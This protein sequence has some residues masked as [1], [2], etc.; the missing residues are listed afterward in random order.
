[1]PYASAVIPVEAELIVV[2]HAETGSWRG[3]RLLTRAAVARLGG[4]IDATG[5]A[6]MVG[7]LAPVCRRSVGARIVQ[8]VATEWP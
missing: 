6:T 7:W 5:E 3:M 4:W 2:G 8:K 1:M